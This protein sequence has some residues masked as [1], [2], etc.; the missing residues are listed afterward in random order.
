[1]TP[2]DPSPAAWKAI[3][4]KRYGSTLCWIGVGCIVMSRSTAEQAVSIFWA[5]SLVLSVFIAGQSLVD[6]VLTYV[7]GNGE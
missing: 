1:M 3:V 5:L 4:R 6:A 2:Y 7:R